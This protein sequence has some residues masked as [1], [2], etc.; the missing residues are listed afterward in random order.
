MGRN[1]LILKWLLLAGALYFLAVSIAHM[2]AIKVPLLFVYYNVPSHA[3]QD[4]II[5]F[6]S[7]GWAIFL[8]T[9]SLDP[10]KNRDLVKAIL[11]AGIGAIFGLHV[12]NTVTDFHALS[13]DIHP[14]V[15]R[16][17]SL[18]LSVYVAALIIF[19]FLSKKEAHGQA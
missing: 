9:A 4:R 2:L 7:F 1:T 5:S 10:L 15:F 12:I 19:Y 6:L 16:L 17:E 8:F 18:G 14:R 13:P 11:I 3:Y